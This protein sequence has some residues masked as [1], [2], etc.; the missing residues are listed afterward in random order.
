MLYERDVLTAKFFLDWYRSPD[1]KLFG[2]EDPSAM[3]EMKE[4]MGTFIKRLEAEE[5]EYYDEEDDEAEK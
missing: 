5:Y 4:L 3:H 1:T 2:M